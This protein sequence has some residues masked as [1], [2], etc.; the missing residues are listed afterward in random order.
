MKLTT[1]IRY[2]TRALVEIAA[3]SGEEPVPLKVIAERQN[4][5]QAYLEQ[6]ILSLK[7]AGLVRS[8]RGAKGGF[9]MVRDPK[10]ITMMEVV[11]ILGGKLEVTE[12]VKEPGVCSRS[13]KCAVRDFWN[14]IDEAIEGVLTSTTL[15]DLVD[16]QRKTE[17][18]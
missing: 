13:A 16:W 2:G 1:R 12:C 3:N 11:E 10:T 6:L 17:K 5:S 8:V 18:A 4:L 14:R 7:A 9:L 15:A